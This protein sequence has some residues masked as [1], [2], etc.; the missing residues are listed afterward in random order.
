MEK[1]QMSLRD[2]PSNTQQPQ[3]IF[4]KVFLAEPSA[5]KTTTFLFGSVQNVSLK[6]GNMDAPTS[7]P[8]APKR[9]APTFSFGVAASKSNENVEK[10]DG[11]HIFQQYLLIMH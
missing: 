8:S 6:G 1:G 7:S 9:M 5:V 11:M 10:A 3:A 2:S 4:S